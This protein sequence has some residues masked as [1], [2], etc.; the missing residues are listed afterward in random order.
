[1]PTE[2]YHKFRLGAFWA[3]WDLP[4]Y[5]VAGAGPTGGALPVERHTDASALVE[6][7]YFLS[8]SVSIGGWW[9]Q[10]SGED[11][12]TARRDLRSV[13]ATFDATFWDLHVTYYPTVTWTNGLS[14]QLGVNTLRQEVT[15]SR[16]LGGV[17]HVQTNNSVNLWLSKT[18]Q[19]G[20]RGSRH[21]IFVYG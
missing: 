20:N 7:D 6:A 9:N 14:V 17:K 8:D 16:Q 12:Q 5:S 10:I 13:I 15:R 11:R 2:R 3:K 21:P 4:S 18:Q 19:L 1:T